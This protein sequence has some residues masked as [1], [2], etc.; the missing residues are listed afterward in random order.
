VLRLSELLGRPVT[1][2]GERLGRLA[3]LAVGPEHGEPALEALAL[4]GRE[5][6]WLA[7]QAGGSASEAGIELGRSPESI[8][9]PAGAGRLQLRRHV[10]DSQV[11][12]VE[13]R[14]LL[15][16][17]DVV[18][19]ERKGDLR[20]I[21]VEIGAAPLLRRLGL[22]ALARRSTEELL[23]WDQLHLAS[24]PGHVLQLGMPRARIH[25]LS[26]PQVQDLLNA[27]PP[28]RARELAG[29]AGIERPA[30]P[31]LPPRKRRGPRFGAVL[32]H[33]RHAPR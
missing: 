21:G 18:L 11:I 7:W 8:P 12:D 24:A 29:A 3:D 26:E 16:V 4:R 9:A 17:S 19:A 30:P 32:R 13:G 25:R 33:R 20:L 23:G 10:L 1:A 15:R 27:L 2:G 14:R 22:G 28:I 6:R 31:K 5:P